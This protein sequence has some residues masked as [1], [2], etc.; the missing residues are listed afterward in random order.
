MS[1]LQVEFKEGVL[2]PLSVWDQGHIPLMIRAAMVTAPKLVDNVMV[3]TSV[4]REPVSR[5]IAL[6]NRKSYHEGKYDG[7]ARAIDIR[8]GLSGTEREDLQ[9][10][11]ARGGINPTTML[12]GDVPWRVYVEAEAWAARMRLRLGIEHDIVYG[13][14]RLHINHIHMEHDYRKEIVGRR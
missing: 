5:D 6:A 13:I 9:L 11:F 10:T 1:H 3:V 14:P 2:L 12:E 4:W 8:T 7:Q